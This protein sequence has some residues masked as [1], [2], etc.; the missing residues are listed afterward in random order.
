MTGE[1]S[2]LGA[3]G[4]L[5]L[6]AFTLL[7]FA[8]SAFGGEPLSMHEARLPQVSRQMLA[9]GN[10]LLPRSGTRPWLERP[11]LP[12]WILIAWGHLVGRLD[13][14]WIVRLP[15]ALAGALTCLVV[16]AS[17]ARL[18]GRTRGL[19]SGLLLATTYEFQLYA[20][21]AEEE[22]YLALLVASAVALF[23]RLSPSLAGGDGGWSRRGTVLAGTG[24][25]A[26]LALAH[27][28][29][30]P[31]VGTV[32][33]GSIVGSYLVVHA[34][35]Q[36][37]GGALFEPFGWLGWTTGLLAS[38]LLGAAWYLYAWRV[39]PSLLD[40]LEYDFAGPFGHDPAWYYLPTIAWTA[41][42]WFLFAVIGVVVIVRRREQERLS[43]SPAAGRFLVCAAIAPIVVLSIPA[44]KHHHY[45]VPVLFGWAMLASIGLTAC[46]RAMLR[47]PDRPRLPLVAGVVGA[48]AATVAIVIL[49]IKDRLPGGTVHAASLVAIL[50]PVIAGVS[51]GFARRRATLALASLLVGH[52]LVSGWLHSA[53]ATVPRRTAERDFVREA[54][55]LVPEDAALCIVAKEAL[56]FFLHQFYSRAGA[57]LLHNITFVRERT[58]SGATVY[59]ITRARD[60]DYLRREIGDVEPLLT[61][62][63][64]RRTRDP[65]DAWT[66]FRVTFR[67]GLE[68]F[69]PPRIDVMQAMK[70]SHD[71]RK[72]DVLDEA[73]FLG[74]R[75]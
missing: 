69:D 37:R 28:V 12:H 3:R 10:W 22:V 20:G 47:L 48:M 33:V 34:V 64:T 18:L 73:P 62:A 66:L 35:S 24:F 15:S 65:R 53:M 7:L 14:E 25:F 67:D 52:L 70:R 68:R 21:R 60:A 43:F 57:R 56:D 1:P 40:N 9:E 38:L 58:L 44:R 71:W 50:L 59:V 2:T 6:L 61:S 54:N 16:A 8:T 32:L 13:A 39:E 26:L 4:A 45:L 30:G 36:R 63:Y 42:P 5:L 49:A 29:R 19:L 41:S 11:P 72:A 75:P 31:M 55:R 23:V 51:L 46:W 17:A 27:L 74:A